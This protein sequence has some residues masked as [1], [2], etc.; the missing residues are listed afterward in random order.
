[1]KTKSPGYVLFGQPPN[2]S[3]NLNT[4]PF[5]A[6]RLIYDTRSFSPKAKAS[7]FCLLAKYHSIHSSSSHG[8]HSNANWKFQSYAAPAME[9]NRYF[10]TPP[11]VYGIFKQ[12]LKFRDQIC[13]SLE[14]QSSRQK[15]SCV[16][17]LAGKLIMMDLA[18]WMPRGQV[19]FLTHVAS[20]PNSSNQ[21]LL[22]DFSK[23][24]FLVSH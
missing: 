3:H 21:K 23:I 22:A 15:W 12:L 20:T 7:L 18:T 17:P 5:I 14:L 6:S 9:V 24:G 11:N 4:L 13:L 19:W 1:M 2:T 16:P 8:P 10:Q